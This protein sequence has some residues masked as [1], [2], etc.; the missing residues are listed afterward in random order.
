MIIGHVFLLFPFQVF[1]PLFYSVAAFYYKNYLYFPDVNPFSLHVANIFCFPVCS[2]SVS[3]S[4]FLINRSS[5]FFSLTFDIGKFI[6]ILFY[7]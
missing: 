4:Y 1:C 7:G 5:H 2:F 6:N 3:L